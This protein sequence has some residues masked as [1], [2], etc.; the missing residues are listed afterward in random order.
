VSESIAPEL[1]RPGQAPAFTGISL[2]IPY[3][4]EG[5]VISECLEAVSRSWAKLSDDR[6]GAFELI[7]VD[8]CSPIPY[9]EEGAARPFSFRTWRMEQNGGAGHAR[10]HGAELARFSHLLFVDADVL[11]EERTLGY[12]FDRLSSDPGIKVL[13]GPYART[14]ANRDADMFHHYM[15]V[16]WY[17]NTFL[18]TERTVGCLLRTGCVVF[19]RAYFRGIGG[20]SNSYPKSGGEEH[21]IVSRIAPEAIV[22]DRDFTA[23]HYHDSLPE[24]L[25]KLFR[26]G[27]HYM[28][29]IGRNTHIPLPFKIVSGLKALC[30]LGMTGSLLLA[31]L[32]PVHGLLAY[33]ALFALCALAEGRMM[34]FMIRHRSLAL[35]A[36]A[37][38]F[39]QLEYT[40][41]SLGMLFNMV[42]F[43]RTPA[44]AE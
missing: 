43:G 19:D 16:A 18:I 25:R 14:P 42:R 22:R 38:V 37:V 44:H 1:T 8:D 4:N 23:L 32:S 39:T 40:A 6:R 26:R 27:T 3:F 5:A 9:R 20:F 28:D 33:G 29:T 11:L 35:A 24:R 17:Y 10:N 21:E 13:Q 41:I 30:A 15:A 2:V 31:L 36:L 12:L 7:L 34:L